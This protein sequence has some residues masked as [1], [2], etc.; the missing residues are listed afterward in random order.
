MLLM[1]IQIFIKK[2]ASQYQRNKL[3]A[4]FSQYGYQKPPAHHIK[5]IAWRKRSLTIST[6][7]K[8]WEGEAM[9]TSA[10]WLE[11]RSEMMALKK[12]GII[13]VCSVLWRNA[14]RQIDRHLSGH[15]W[16]NKQEK[17][18]EFIC[19]PEL[20]FVV[21]LRGEKSIPGID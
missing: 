8:L 11:F 12:G 14:A 9:N 15:R 21:V 7:M 4:Y 2:Y 1:N 19:D 5:G 13:E 20:V 17:I 10:A 16:Y 3:K 6:L 18:I